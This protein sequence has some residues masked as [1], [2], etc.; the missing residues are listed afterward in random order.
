MRFKGIVPGQLRRLLK[1]WFGWKWFRG[2]Y[3]S[4]AAARSVSLG[5]DR[6]EILERVIVASRAARDGIAAWDRDGVA[7]M[8]RWV[9]EP[10]LAALK[11]CAAAEGN[12]IDVVDFG[13]SLGSSWRQYGASLMAD[14]RWRVVEQ[15]HYV[16]VGKREFTNE[17]LTFYASLKEASFEQGS[18]TI[19]LS[20]VLQYLETPYE[21]LGDVVRMG[22]RH[23]LIDRTCFW[24]GN[25][26]RLTVQNTPPELGGGSYPC[27]LFSREK[28]LSSLAFAYELK[29]DWPGFDEL[30]P[31]IQFRGMYFT[32]RIGR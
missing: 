14:V 30:D 19:L 24:R 32:R 2:D 11:A 16:E 9:H 10:F 6:Q 12:R 4:W 1:R 20:S 21:L 29:S 13:G 18:T 8:D 27:W 31:D 28:L 5:Y 7:F 25:R 26:D 3:L 23:V 17:R 15:P 22:F